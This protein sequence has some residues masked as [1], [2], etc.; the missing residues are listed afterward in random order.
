MTT[1]IRRQY[2]SI[3]AE[4]ND[5]LL[6]FRMGDFYETFD[7]DAEI[8]SKDLDIALTSREMGKDNRVPLAGIPY[9]ALDSYLA[10]LINKGHKIAICEQITDIEN[11]SVKGLMDREV[12]RVITPGTIIEP[13]I[14][15]DKKNNYIVSLVLKNNIATI[16]FIDTSSS[17]IIEI[18]DTPSINLPLELDRINPAEIISS[19]DQPA[20]INEF[21]ITNSNE[22][23]SNVAN[24]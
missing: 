22:S 3:K 17:N 10:K 11:S 24:S 6:L 19:E 8:I 9:H 13:S 7:N 12:V 21:I 4:H 18:I 23:F 1:P 2:L 14:L 16:A 20:Q 5:A 15:N